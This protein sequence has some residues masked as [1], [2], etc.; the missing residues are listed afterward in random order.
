MV[1]LRKQVGI[2]YKEK[3]NLRGTKNQ[4][5]F[6]M[7]KEK[8]QNM[9]IQSTKLWIGMAEEVLRLH[10]ETA[11]KLTIHQWLQHR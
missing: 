9:G 7:P 11:T 8:R 4:G 3:R 6:N 5:I 1:R 10:R 2:L